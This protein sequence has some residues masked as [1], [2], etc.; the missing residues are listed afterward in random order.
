MILS[1]IGVL[2]SLIVGE[3]PFGIIMSGI[4]VISLAGV[5]VKNAIVLLDF[6]EKLRERG[7]EKTE[8][9]VRAGMI[10]L[11]PVLLTAITAML[12]LLPMVID[13][14]FDFYKFEVVTRSETAQWWRQMAIV[15]FFGLGVA[16]LLTLVIVP[17]M[18]SALESVKAACGMGWAPPEPD[19]PAV[20]RPEFETA[21]SRVGAAGRLS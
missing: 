3:M 4:G 9:L 10:R 7:Y 20:R 21:G 16:T 15:V 17:V 19:T 6:V 14:S 8:A 1:F 2:L 18:Y 5:V 11:R 13:V 12:G